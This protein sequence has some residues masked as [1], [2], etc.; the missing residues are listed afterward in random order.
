MLKIQNKIIKHYQMNHKS[1]NMRFH[2]LLELM[3]LQ[4][5]VIDIFNEAVKFCFIC[6]LLSILASVEHSYERNITIT[7]LY[8]L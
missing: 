3:E 7:L 5:T 8:R 6:Q 2:Y 1:F 4:L